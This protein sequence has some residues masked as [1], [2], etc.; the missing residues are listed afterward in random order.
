MQAE[1]RKRLQLPARVTLLPAY[2]S[3]ELF[4]KGVVQPLVREVAQRELAAYE[5]PVQAF[6][7]GGVHFRKG[8]DAARAVIVPPVA[9]F[10]SLLGAIGHLAKLVY[11]LLRLATGAVPAWRGCAGCGWCRWGC[12]PPAPPGCRWPAMR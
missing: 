6:E 11:L 12:W 1:L 5:A 10:F 2:G 3:A 8:E 9:L 4:E 7:P